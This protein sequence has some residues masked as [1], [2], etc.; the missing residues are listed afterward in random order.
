MKSCK[1]EI[2]RKYAS[3]SHP[4]YNSEKPAS[5]LIPL[6]SRVIEKKSKVDLPAGEQAECPTNVRRERPMFMN[7]QNMQSMHRNRP[8][9]V[10]FQKSW[11]ETCNF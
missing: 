6:Y 5:V 9:V 2:S 3:E 8:L 4:H 10:E 7:H 11:W 1:S